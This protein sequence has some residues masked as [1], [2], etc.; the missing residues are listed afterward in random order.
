M[1][2]APL[3][4]AVLM[5]C[6]NRSHL[7]M[8]CLRA[9][10]SQELPPEA[11]LQVYL[12]DDN[13]KDGTSQAVA[14]EFPAVRILRGSGNLFWC[15]GMRLAWQEAA[16]EKPDFYL[17]LNDD[18]YLLP[19]AIQQLL[20]TAVST[21]IHPL[22][23][24]VVGSCQDPETKAFTYGGQ[25]RPGLHPGRLI[26]VIPNGNIQPCD[27]FEGNVVLVPRLIFEKVGLLDSFCHAMGDTDY[28]YRVT[29]AGF[30]IR[31]APTF[32]AL[33]AR[34]PPATLPISRFGRLRA[35]MN[36]KSLP[37]MD[38]WKICCRHAGWV[39]PF[40]W[41]WS[42]LKTLISPARSPD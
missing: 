15:R 27:T 20:K 31:V 18:S 42:Y 13:S 7:T 25:I 24:V 4:V 41:A 8:R 28:G 22:P 26:P 11:N 5:T 10:C 37:P 34:N 9:L 23:A 1:K 21:S 19:G 39:G 16:Q 12:V 38:W 40:F 30:V 6:H 35:K 2:S 29:R 33:C 17:W 3:S 32:V 36:R 14:R